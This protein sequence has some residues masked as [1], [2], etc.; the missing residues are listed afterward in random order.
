M[1]SIDSVTKV[2]T[3]YFAAVTKEPFTYK[4]KRYTPKR[5]RVSPNL[6]TRVMDCLPNCGGCCRAFTMDWLPDEHRDG[7]T[8]D[9]VKERMVQFNGGE[10]P[11]LSDIQEGNDSY[12]CR[13]LRTDDGR[14][15][16]HDH[17]ALSCEFELLRFNMFAK[18]TSANQLSNRPFGRGWAML[19]I[20][21]KRGALCHDTWRDAEPD[22]KRIADFA[23]RLKRLKDWTDH[24]GIETVLPEIIEWVETGPHKEPLFVGKTYITE[25]DL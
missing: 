21:G 3:Q 10:F 18:V 20:D 16:I 11:V 25:K 14:C 15:D 12:Y 9:H 17:N 4:K 19:R 2:I 8:A 6:F 1:N 13:Y 22:P 23:G 7:K 24:F 5:L